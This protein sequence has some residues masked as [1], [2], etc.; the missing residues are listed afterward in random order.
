MSR[1]PSLQFKDSIK[2][3]KKQQQQK[4]K[5]RSKNKKKETKT[6]NKC[7]GSFNMWLSILKIYVFVGCYL[8]FA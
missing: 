4:A 3:T 1:R 8:V 7:L 5:K 6:N 2:N